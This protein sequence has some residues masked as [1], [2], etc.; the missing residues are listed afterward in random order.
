MPLSV[1][2]ASLSRSQKDPI[3]YS[4]EAMRQDLTRVRVA[5]KECQS[6]RNRDAIYA[7]LTA[8]Y[9]LVTWWA[10]E[11]QDLARAQRAVRLS[12]QTP[13]VSRWGQ[14][15]VGLPLAY[16]AQFP[17]REPIQ[18]CNPDRI[19]PCRFHTGQPFPRVGLTETANL[20]R[21]AAPIALERGVTRHEQKQTE[22]RLFGSSGVRVALS[23]LSLL[24]G[25]KMSL[26]R[27]V[28]SVASIFLCQSAAFAQQQTAATGVIYACKN[29]SNG[30]P[31]IVAANTTCPRNWT[32]ISWNV[33][34]PP[35][36]I[37][38][39]GPLG[40]QGVAGPQ[41]A[42]GPQGPTGP[43][44]PTGP[45]GPAG[46]TGPSTSMDGSKVV[47]S[48]VSTPL[49]NGAVPANG[50]MVQA[51]LNASCVVNDNGPADGTALANGST[52]AGFLFTTL[53]VT[54]A[55]Y[56]PIGT[57]SVWCNNAGYV[58]ARSW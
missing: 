29:N 31:R 39:Q 15:S 54:P 2:P 16:A 32:L 12:G 56:K 35:G 33:A 23:C 43:R 55:G 11:G 48:Q 47:P 41:G 6:S 14:P 25:I 38:P 22:G 10:A 34:G 5:W 44:G 45:T 52:V 51:A 3:P 57:V 17:V 18:F 21:A 36:P 7:Y 9:A 50:F 40:A 53:F 1:L 20:T 24:G 28:A 4:A 46:P 27:T 8:V 13:L 30:D 37:G 19:G 26:S 42:Q 49:F 58:A